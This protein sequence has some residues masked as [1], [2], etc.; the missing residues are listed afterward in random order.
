MPRQYIAGYDSQGRPIIRSD[1]VS[2]EAPNERTAKAEVLGLSVEAITLAKGGANERYILCRKEKTEMPQVD[3]GAQTPTV[4]LQ[5]D[6]LVADVARIDAAV[7]EIRDIV[8]QKQQNEPSPTHTIELARNKH[9]T[10]I[11]SKQVGEFPLE[12]RTEIENLAVPFL[13]NAERVS[14]SFTPAEQKTPVA[15]PATSTVELQKQVRDLS[16]VVLALKKQLETRAAE[17]TAANAPE[18]PMQVTKQ[19]GDEEPPAPSRQSPSG[20][21]P[22]PKKWDGFLPP[23]IKHEMQSRAKARVGQ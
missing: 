6:G 17:P 21:A 10:I 12:A 13:N 4:G 19:V 1:H 14:I 16:D 3:D 15:A 2:A 8:L 20:G 11:V 22:A 7:R 18:A 23:G 5:M 9:G